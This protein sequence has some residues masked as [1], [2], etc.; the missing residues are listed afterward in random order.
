MPSVVLPYLITGAI[1][2]LG[3]LIFTVLMFRSRVAS[4]RPAPVLDQSGRFGEDRFCANCGY[5]VRGLL[6]NQNCPECNAVISTNPM[7]NPPTGENGAVPG[8]FAFSLTRTVIG[9]AVGACY[10]EFMDTSSRSPMIWAGLA[11]FRMLEWL[12]VIGLFWRYFRDDRRGA[13]IVAVYG[14]GWSYLLDIPVALGFCV[15]Y[16]VPC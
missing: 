13:V 12:F 5:N 2:F 14:T 1:K 15:T 8:Y 7:Q 9:L 3:Y 10:W 4:T 16:G 11:P 6:P